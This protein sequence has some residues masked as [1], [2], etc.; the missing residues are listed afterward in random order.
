MFYT[1]PRYPVELIDRWTL[2]DG[3]VLTLRPILPQDAAIET[4]FVQALSVES[5][6]ARFLSGGRVTPETV[7]AFTAVDHD[8]HLAIVV[9]TWRDGEEELVADGRYVREGD[10]AEFAVVVADD[11][12]GKGIGRRLIAALIRTARARGVRVL[13]GDVLSEN[14]RMLGIVRDVGFAVRTNLEDPRL[15]RVDLRLADDTPQ[16]QHVHFAALAALPASPL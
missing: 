12:Q 2:A 4:C 8:R 6:Y 15:Q 9:T 16:P 1:I 10:S 7:R 14:R 3:T 13:T 11:W 5:R